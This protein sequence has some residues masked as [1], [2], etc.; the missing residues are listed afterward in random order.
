MR[1]QAVFY[2]AGQAVMVLL[3]AL[4]LFHCAVLCGIVPQEHVWGGRA[5]ASD[6]LILLEVVALVITLLFLFIVVVRVRLPLHNSLHGVV[7]LALWIMTLYFLL[8]VIGNI[9]SFSGWERVVFTPVST[10]LAAGCCIMAIGPK[11]Q[12]KEK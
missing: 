5:A 6:S 12:R 1:N 9:A 3:T 10:L 8:N 11:A 7:R 2:G 4:A